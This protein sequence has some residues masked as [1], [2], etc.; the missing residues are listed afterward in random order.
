MPARSID[1]IN[2]RNWQ[3]NPTTV[4]IPQYQFDLQIKWTDL[5]GGKHEHNGT[6]RYPND[7]A[8]MPLNVRRKFAEKMIIATVRVALGIST[9]DDYA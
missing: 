5:Q 7:I 4:R 9:W 6:Y 2:S 3:E 1:E 8:E